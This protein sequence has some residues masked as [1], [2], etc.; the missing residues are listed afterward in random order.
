MTTEQAEAYKRLKL[1][2]KH[3]GKG[4]RSKEILQ[5]LFEEQFKA[6]TEANAR[7]ASAMEPAHEALRSAFSAIPGVRDAINEIK[8]PERLELPRQYVV[9]APKEPFVRFGSF[10]V[11]DTP[12][13]QALTGQSGTGDN[14]IVLNAE[15]SGNMTLTLD[16]GLN[17]SGNA[18]CWCAIGQ[19]YVTPGEALLQFSSTPSL[20]WSCEW[21]SEWWRQAAGTV[22]IGQVINM[23]DLDGNYLGAPVAT[24]INQY[25]YNDYNFA[26][27]GFQQGQS[28]GYLLASQANCPA[29]VVL[30][31]WVVIGCYANADGA[32]AQSWSYNSLGATVPSLQLHVWS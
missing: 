1:V 27:N 6:R 11:V 32:N 5:R 3:H 4:P 2:P 28:S 17:N 26:D 20:S 12:P 24:Q 25:S 13:F 14:A 18:Q 15:A 22:W 23:W 30:E 9:N 19:E 16:A 29:S 21:G 31:C 10:L 7:I 8:G